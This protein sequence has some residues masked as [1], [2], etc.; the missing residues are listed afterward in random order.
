MFWF[1]KQLTI[2]NAADALAFMVDQ[3]ATDY[4][5]QSPWAKDVCNDPRVSTELRYLTMF[6]VD[7]FFKSLNGEHAWTQGRDKLLKQLYIK[8]SEQNNPAHPVTAMFTFMSRLN[9]Y[10]NAIRSAK[11]AGEGS[12]L[13]AKEFARF[14]FMDGNEGLSLLG[15]AVLP[16]MLRHLGPFV[17]EH[18]LV[19]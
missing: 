12:V 3:M 13:A 8:C 2:E 18:R 17:F 7:G 4:L 5:K 14:C 9:A 16:I 1:Q 10:N 19:G 11:S 15:S 6:Y